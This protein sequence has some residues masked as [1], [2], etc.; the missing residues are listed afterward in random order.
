MLATAMMIRTTLL[1]LLFALAACRRT[2]PAP[3]VAAGQAASAV[4]LPG[5]V[6]TT[7]AAPTLPAV[8]FARETGMQP[9]AAEPFEQVIAKVLQA[10]ANGHTQ[11]LQP[12]LAESARRRMANGTGSSGSLPIQAGLVR[13]RLGDGRIERVIFQGGRALVLVRHEGKLLMSTFYLE[14]GR[15]LFDA[16]DVTPFSEAA[17][18]P[19]D[20][21]NH[22]IT[23]QEATAGLP[24]QGELVATLETT[25]GPIRCVLHA[26][27]APNTVANFV[28]LARGLR[29]SAQIAEGKLTSGFGLKRFYDGMS[30]Y[31][32]VVGMLAETG[33]PLRHGPGHAGYQIADELDLRLRHDKPGVLAMAS[34]GPNTSSSA[35]YITARPTPWLNDRRT[36]F[37]LC[38]NQEVI[39]AVTRAP[40]GSV[41]IRTVTI[42][43][44]PP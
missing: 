29:A 39:E 36:I 4:A 41:T 27:V 1:A 6:T 35:F 42:S 43:R 7:A 14:Q 30:F 40:A 9:A 32:S 5:A 26:D 34:N 12:L 19:G 3:P 10:V 23:L 11:E 16:G 31:R 21:L 22:P 44:S 17:S 20:P 2:P 13:R 37:G 8:H 24:A 18:G 38:G 28:G 15:W 25:L 33:D